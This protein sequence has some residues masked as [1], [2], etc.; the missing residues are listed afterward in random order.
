MVPFQQTLYG[1]TPVI[2][3]YDL[4]INGKGRLT[5]VTQPSSAATQSPYLA[6]TYTYDARGLVIAEERSFSIFDGQFKDAR[7]T[8][9]SYNALAQPNAIT[10]ADGAQSVQ[11]TTVQFSYDDRGLPF[12]ATWQGKGPLGQVQYTAAGSVATKQGALP[13]A[14]PYGITYVYDDLGR[15]IRQLMNAQ[16]PN[17]PGVTGSTT[18]SDQ[19][20]TY[21]GSDDVAMLAVT[22]GPDLQPQYGQWTFTYDAQHQ[23]RTANGPN[24]QATFNYSPAGRVVAAA[25]RGTPQ[26]TR[27]VSYDYGTGD[28]ETPDLLKQD[29]GTAWMSI[30]YDEAGNATHRSVQGK[31]WVHVYDGADLQR[32]VTAPDG[33]KE[34]Y[35]YDGGR[36]RSLVAMLSATGQ[37]QRLRWLFG[38]TEIWYD[39][40]GKVVKTLANVS[41][42]G[43]L[44][45][46]EGDASGVRARV[47]FENTRGDQLI[48]LDQ[49]GELAAE[50]AYGPYGE[51]LKES[52]SEPAAVLE[53]LMASSST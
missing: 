37:V 50:F 9:R 22:F 23:L 1:V 43:P 28:P 53:R 10:Y 8:V 16:L 20:Y 35:W 15:A 48:A 38:E 13:N 39:G 31:T 30:R 52:G 49:Q 42:N 3:T 51:Q 4:G 29:D 44:A 41:L 36:Q 14:I 21:T 25:V 32:E 18:L 6:T 46:I 17:P 2:Y 27:S 26:I 5:N 12:A 33:S 7:K 34:L 11:P 45:R 40:S 47:L 24:Y 19:S